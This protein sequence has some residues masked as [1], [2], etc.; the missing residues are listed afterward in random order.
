MFVFY[1]T[2]ATLLL[3]S[4]EYSEPVQAWPEAR[5]EMS[6]HF[7]VDDL[8]VPGLHPF[9]NPTAEGRVLHCKHAHIQVVDRSGTEFPHM[10][11]DVLRASILHPNLISR[12]EIWTPPLTIEEARTEMRKWLP[13]IER[14]EEELDTFLALVDEDWLR[15][16]YVS[17]VPN[18]NRFSAQW[19]DPDGMRMSISLIKSWQWQAPLRLQFR[20]TAMMDSRYPVQLVEGP[21]EPPPGHDDADLTAPRNWEADDRF[22]P[23][24]NEFRPPQGELP[25]RFRSSDG[26]AS[27]TPPKTTPDYGPV[28]ESPENVDK[29]PESRSW[30]K[31]VAGVVVVVLIVVVSVIARSR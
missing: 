9:R 19:S 6:E 16:D 13:F 22:V 1:L 20:V 7:I 31:W 29:T 17:G 8:F 5:L 21:I 23:L 12:M 15:Y 25:P 28:T 24:T 30:I 27:E 26:N 18:T 14:T 10:P 11:T 2:T 4:D 3:A